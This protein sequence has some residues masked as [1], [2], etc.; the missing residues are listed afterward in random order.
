MNDLFYQAPVGHVVRVNFTDFSFRKGA[1]MKDPSSPM[2]GR[3][4]KEKVEIRR[5]E[6]INEPEM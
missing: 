1:R 6:D 3:C 4:I 2:N 5:M